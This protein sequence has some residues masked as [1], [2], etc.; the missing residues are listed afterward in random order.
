MSRSGSTDEENNMHAEQIELPH[1]KRLCNIS[2]RVWEDRTRNNSGN[3]PMNFGLF[4][5]HNFE[6][7]FLSQIDCHARQSV[8][9]K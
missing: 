3:F 9:R 6:L 1:E 4:V 7:C 5:F 8:I 2:K